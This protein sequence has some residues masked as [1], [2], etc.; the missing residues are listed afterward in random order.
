MAARGDVAVDIDH[1]AI[2]GETEVPLA[3]GRRGFGSR[4]PRNQ[5]RRFRQVVREVVRRAL[6]AGAP[7]SLVTVV[8]QHG[9]AARAPAGFDIVEDV[10]DQPRPGEVDAQILRRLQQ[11]PRR[12]LAAI[13]GERESVHAARGVVRAIIEPVQWRPGGGEELGPV[14]ETRIGRDGVAV[15]RR[16]SP[17]PSRSR[18]SKGMQEMV[19]YGVSFDMVGKQPIVLL[20]TVS[21]NKFL[22]IWIGHAE[23]AAILGL[24]AIAAVTTVG[25]GAGSSNCALS[26][27][28]RLTAVEISVASSNPSGAGLSSAAAVSALTLA[29]RPRSA[30]RSASRARSRRTSAARS[31]TARRG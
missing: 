10:A 16:E 19:I 7:F 20:K 21:G 12:G 13:A 11:Q 24:V 22:P 3:G 5:P 14:R 29:A 2:G 4:Q 28:T 8:E 6:R 25:A 17:L 1:P 27:A 23:A 30:S 31:R 9:A 18:L 26:W 15:G